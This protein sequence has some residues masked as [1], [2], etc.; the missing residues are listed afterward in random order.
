MADDAGYDAFDGDTLLPKN[1]FDYGKTKTKTFEE[2]SGQ[3]TGSTT[4]IKSVKPLQATPAPG[5]WS[6]DNLMRGMGDIS[7]PAPENAAPTLGT[8]VGKTKDQITSGLNKAYPEVFDPNTN[9][10]PEIDPKWG[11][12][13]G[14]AAPLDIT[15]PALPAGAARKPIEKVA[16][17]NSRTPSDSAPA[18]S[19]AAHIT[20]GPPD[21]NIPPPEAFPPTQDLSAKELPPKASPTEQQG[22]PRRG[23]FGI[24]G[25]LGEFGANINN[26]RDQNRMQL[27][28]LAGGLAGAPSLGQGFGRGFTAAANAMPEQQKLN[29]QNSTVNYLMKTGNLDRDQAMAIMGNPQLAHEIMGQMSGI[30]PPKMITVEPGKQQMQ[31]NPATRHF[32]GING[33]ATASSDAQ[34]A[35]WDAMSIPDRLANVRRQYGPEWADGVKAIGEGRAVPPNRL[36]QYFSTAQHVYPGLDLKAYQEAQKTQN[37]FA[38]NGVS[39][40]NLTAIQTAMGHIDRMQQNGIALG[41]FRTAPLLN[42][43]WNIIRSQLSPEFQRTAAQFEAGATGSS[44]ELA[45]AFRAAGMSEADID[46]WLKM[47]NRDSSPETINGAAEEAI[48]MLDSRLDAIATSYNRGMPPHAEKKTA[49]TFIDEMGPKF[50]A[51]HDKIGNIKHPQTQ[52]PPQTQGTATQDAGIFIVNQNGHHYQRMPDGS[53]KQLD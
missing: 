46:R 17:V 11:P 16:D 30:L 45:K 49:Q 7:G 41:N 51:L 53:M 50:Q 36:S 5:L 38:P 15:A 21:P 6:R 8:L 19:L 44:G 47:F 42:T 32:E 34:A 40:K 23:L 2:A 22:Q 3:P 9:K 27:L 25:L 28:M 24:P 33:A 52:T 12:V 35:A 29:T 4:G 18:G 20:E 1:P 48:H 39:G 37:D 31:W 43:P 13:G 10:D 14:E 26:W